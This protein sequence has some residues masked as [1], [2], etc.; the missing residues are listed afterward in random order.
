MTTC[1]E[2]FTFSWPLRGRGEGAVSLTAFFL[3]FFVD[4][5][6]YPR[7]KGYSYIYLHQPI[8]VFWRCTFHKIC[9]DFIPNLY[10]FC[11]IIVQTWH[12]MLKGSK[13][14]H[15]FLQKQ[16]LRPYFYIIT[17][18]VCLCIT[19]YKILKFSFN[20]TP[21]MMI[22]SWKCYFGFHCSDVDVVPN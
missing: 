14:M 10:T 11:V 15:Q 8:I 21:C 4:A 12:S 20:E 17:V 16:E 13:N 22:R 9:N 3:F 18:S 19:Q 1:R 6:P 5:F 2:F 7:G